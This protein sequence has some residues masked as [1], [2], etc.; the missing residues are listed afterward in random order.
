MISPKE[1]YETLQNL[2]VDFYAGVPDSLLKDLC[3]YITEHNKDNHIISANEGS[4]VGLAIGHHLATGKVPVIYMQNSGLG[5]IVN[6]I[7]SMADKDVYGIPML[8]I[9]GW[10][11]EMENGEQLKDEPQHK[12]QGRLTCEI[13][14]AMEIPYVVI[15]KDTDIKTVLN[16]MVA[17]TKK[18]SSPVAILVRKGTFEKYSLESTSNGYDMTRENAIEHFVD[19][20]TE[21]DV[22]VG[23]TGMPSRELF[24]VRKAKGHD[25]NDFLCVGGMGHASSIA[26]GVAQANTN[27]TVWCL[28]G[29]GALIMHMGALSVNKDYDINHVVLNNGAHDSVG[30]QP[31]VA[32]EIDLVDVAKGNGYKWG[33][34]VATE[35]ELKTAL[36]EIKSAPKPAFLEIRVAKGNRPDLGRPTLT[37]VETKNIFMKK[38]DE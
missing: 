4:S 7:L 32:F 30:G 1:V 19:T 26:V 9:I 13:L 24:E 37:P 20:L 29:D 2:E 22:V 33:K 5:N 27:K 10:R 25:N 8:M 28:D 18:L 16:D 11:G 3:A 14:D 6:P 23:T 21:N 36:T 15:D 17:K 34:S 31:T 38:V 35:D 12:T